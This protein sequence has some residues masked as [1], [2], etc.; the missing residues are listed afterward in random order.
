[1]KCFAFAVVLML[2]LK[3]QQN[4]QSKLNVHDISYV[5]ALLQ[6]YKEIFV[7]KTWLLHTIFLNVKSLTLKTK[8][9]YKVGS[10]CA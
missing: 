3:L 1:M 5:F 10:C 4:R 6:C 2:Y 9:R 8:K 7:G